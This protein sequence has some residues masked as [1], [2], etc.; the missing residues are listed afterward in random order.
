MLS[1][2]LVRVLGMVDGALLLV[3]ANEGPLSQTKFVVEKALKHGLRPI[4]VLNKASCMPPLLMALPALM[5][6][7]NQECL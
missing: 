1:P 2:L 7:R 4:V 3:D 5:C 6:S